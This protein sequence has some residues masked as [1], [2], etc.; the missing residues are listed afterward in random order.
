M[1][2]SASQMGLSK[3][4]NHTTTENGAVTNSTTG[5]A[6]LDF[7]SLGGALRSRGTHDQIALF[8]RAWNENPLGALRTM[9]YFRD[10][11]GGQGQRDA[12]RAQFAHLAQHMPTVANKNLSNVPFYGRWDDLYALVNTPLKRHALNLLATQLKNDFVYMDTDDY[13]VSL[14]G[15]W[16][17]SENTSSADSTRLARETIKV[18][19][20]SP[21]KYRKV[22][23]A[24][25]K[26]LNVLETQISRGDWGA[27]E[28]SHVPSNAMLK[29]RNAFSTHDRE[30]FSHFLTN[31][32]EGNEKIN[33]SVLYPHDI[34]GKL[35]TDTISGSQ[36]QALWDALP[37]YLGEEENSIAVVD[38]SASMNGLP[39]QVSIA[40]GM[41]LAE[42][43][44]GAWKDRFITFS[45]HP[46]MNV[47]GGKSIKTRVNSLRR[48]HWG[49]NTNIERVFDVILKT[50]R[51][52]HVAP[53]DM[54]DKLYVISDMEFDDAMQDAYGGGKTLFESF[55]A[56]YAKYGYELPNLVMWNVDA[57]N[58]QFPMTMDERGFQ[59]VSGF[60][61]SILKHL[62]SGEFLSAEDMMLEVL[63]SERYSRIT[64]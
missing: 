28:Y 7:F 34:V 53:A 6:L 55:R 56:K 48:S 62:M 22:L 42:H 43:A 20:V 25:R 31:V 60:S 40:L 17:K 46:Q 30:R 61:P 63:N 9:F 8:N 15:K 27:V 2:M 41:Y 57:R 26:R 21:R 13:Q 19:G 36:A 11:R 24:L 4:L 10:P 49:M 12:F 3:A 54:I 18:M 44:K 33:A 35:L 47:I 16:A 45:E 58:D 52:E 23:S 39:I 5:S 37:E 64:L 38:V 59:A 14:A 32:N 29:Y 50:A 51:L 1:N